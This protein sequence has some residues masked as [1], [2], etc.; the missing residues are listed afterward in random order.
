[1]IVDGDVEKV[2]RSNAVIADTSDYEISIGSNRTDAAYVLTKN[3]I[4]C[5]GNL[6]HYN[7]VQRLEGD[8]LGVVLKAGSNLLPK[9]KETLLVSIVIEELLLVILLHGIE[10]VAVALVKID[11]HVEVILLAP[12]AT[13]LK[14]CEALLLDVAVLILEYDIVNRETDVIEAEASHS[15]DVTLRYVSI[16]MLLAVLTKL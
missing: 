9:L 1:M 14:I 7:L 10:R 15:R 4:P 16:K 11:D 6:I 8:M 5:I 2:N 13:V 3:L 12:P